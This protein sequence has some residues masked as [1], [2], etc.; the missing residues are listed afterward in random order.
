MS[1][2]IRVLMN[3]G[4]LYDTSTVPISFVEIVIISGGSSGS[5]E[6]PLLSGFTLNCAIMKSAASSSRQ[7]LSSF[8]FTYDLG[9]PVLNW[10]PTRTRAAATTQMLLVFAR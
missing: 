5:K 1:H 7:N 6:Y 10:F 2:G 3:D 4:R 9:Y 8:N